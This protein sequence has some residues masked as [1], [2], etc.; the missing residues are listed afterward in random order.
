M[1]GLGYA[2][3]VEITGRAQG[4][5]VGWGEEAGSGEREGEKSTFVPKL[6]KDGAAIFWM[7]KTRGACLE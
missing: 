7:G 2:V 1:A 6:W 4:L 5:A 3:K